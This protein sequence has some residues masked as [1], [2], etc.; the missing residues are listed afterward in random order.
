MHRLGPR[1]RLSLGRF[2]ICGTGKSVAIFDAFG[3][4]DLDEVAAGSAE[5]A[6]RGVRASWVGSGRRRAAA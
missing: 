5:A 1:C 6:R 2:R 3:E 4:G